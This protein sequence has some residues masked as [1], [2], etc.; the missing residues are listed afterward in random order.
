MNICFKYLYIQNYNY[1]LSNILTVLKKFQ[2]SRFSKG[3]AHI[4]SSTKTVAIKP[5]IC[6]WSIY[7]ILT[8]LRYKTVIKINF[9]LKVENIFMLQVGY[10][11]T[12]YYLF[13]Y[14]RVSKSLLATARTHYVHFIRW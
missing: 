10:R 7:Y 4:S 13:S 3:S 5:T 11:Q 8:L 14:P 12:C 6:V 9:L 2:R 1:S